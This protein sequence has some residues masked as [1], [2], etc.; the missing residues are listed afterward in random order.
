MHR[1]IVDLD[2]VIDT[3]LMALLAGGHVLVEGTPGLGK[4]YLARTFAG[5]LALSFKRIQ[6]TSDMLPGD[7]QGSLIF[8]GRRQEFE[9]KPG[10]I[11]ANVVLADEINRAPPRTQSALLEAMQERQVTVEGRRHPL[12]EPFM[13]IATQNPVEQ[14]G[15]YPLP[16]AELDRFYFRAYVRFLRSSSEVEMLQRKQ[17]S[18]EAIDVEPVVSPAEVESAASAVQRVHVERTV[19]EYMAEIVAETRRDPRVL[20]GASARALVTLL[21]VSKARAALEGRSYVTPDDAKQVAP[22]SLNHRLILKPEVVAEGL[23]R[24]EIWSYDL[25]AQV[26]NDALARVRVPP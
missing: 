8:D 6:F 4:T 21:Y 7:I 19:M 9:F 23:G 24:G 26:V 16:E 5:S 20:L 13:V 11:F 14:E 2:D 18:G 15:T 25:V 12:P 3:L 1:V 17:V 22:F 10:P